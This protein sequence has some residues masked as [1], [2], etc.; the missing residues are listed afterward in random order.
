MGNWQW[1]AASPVGLGVF[2]GF[3]QAGNAIPL[4]PLTAP[5]EHFQ[6]LKA[7]EH[8]SLAAQRGRRSQTPML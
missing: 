4:F 6:A 3:A 1:P 2:L 5:L 8:I 7:L